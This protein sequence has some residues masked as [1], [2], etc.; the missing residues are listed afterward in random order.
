MDNEILQKYNKMSL[1]K[2]D[3]IFQ[4]SNENIVAEKIQ[5]SDNDNLNSSAINNEDL[6]TL[7]SNLDK[8]ERLLKTQKDADILQELSEEIK[9]LKET[10]SQIKFNNSKDNPNVKWYYS[11]RF[12]EKFYW[13]LEDG[14]VQFEGGAR[15]N[16]YEIHEMSKTSDFIIQNAHFLKT[17]F[18]TELIPNEYL[19]GKY[20]PGTIEY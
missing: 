14:Y 9:N 19:I 4:N 12:N 1:I 17:K 10:I 3:D 5:L 20:A 18:I 11:S 2:I 7:K 13:N 8:Y 15:Y 16:E 6:A